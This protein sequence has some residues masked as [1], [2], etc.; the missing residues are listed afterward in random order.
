M[1]K[2]VSILAL[3]LF[4]AMAIYAQDKGPVMSFETM[5]IDYGKVMQGSEPIR[6]FK[7][8]NTGNEPLVIT[9]ASAS[10]GCTVPSYPKEPVMPGETGKIEVRYDTNRIGPFQKPISITTN[11]PNGNHTLSIKGTVDPKPGN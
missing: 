7:F 2:L 9:S 10:C 11:E 5:E 1:K 6:V 8:K 3:L 4:G